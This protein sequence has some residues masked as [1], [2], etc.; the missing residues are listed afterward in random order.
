MTPPEIHR[1]WGARR[2]GNYSPTQIGTRDRAFPTEWHVEALV[3]IIAIVLRDPN[4]GRRLGVR[5]NAHAKP[6]ARAGFAFEVERYRQS[7]HRGS[8]KVLSIFIEIGHCAR[9]LQ[10][11][12]S[13]FFFSRRSIEIGDG[14]GLSGQRIAAHFQTVTLAAIRKIL[15]PSITAVD[16]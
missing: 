7:G 13:E 1:T 15:R 8:G 10:E 2:R 5:G 3:P 14:N 9:M 12:L 4:F 6:P 11:G 16:R